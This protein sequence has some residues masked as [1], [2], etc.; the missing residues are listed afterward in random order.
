M[1]AIRVNVT[2][3]RGHRVKKAQVSVKGV[4]VRVPARRTSATGMVVFKLRPRRTGKLT[5]RVTRGG[6]RAGSASLKVAR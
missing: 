4:G 2:D 3:N 6:Y 5:F 1:G